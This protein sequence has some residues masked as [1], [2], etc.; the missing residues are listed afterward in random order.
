VADWATISADRV[1]RA[2]PPGVESFRPLT[3]DQY[4]ASGDVGI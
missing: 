2:S 1:M 4:I 3:R